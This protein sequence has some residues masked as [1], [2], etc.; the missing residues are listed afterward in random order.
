MVKK[1]FLCRIG[2][3]SWCHQGGF[4]SFDFCNYCTKGWPQVWLDAE[5]KQEQNR[6]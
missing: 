1:R 4:A 5:A 6:N 2:I 3:H